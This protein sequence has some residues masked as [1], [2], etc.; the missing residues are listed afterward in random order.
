MESRQFVWNLAKL[1]VVVKHLADQKRHNCAYSGQSRDKSY[2]LDIAYYSSCDEF[3]SGNVTKRQL[4][5]K[6]GLYDKIYGHAAALRSQ[7]CEVGKDRTQIQMSLKTLGI[8]AAS[9][10]KCGNLELSSARQDIFD[11]LISIAD[12]QQRSTV[13]PANMTQNELMIHRSRGKVVHCKM[14][15]FCYMFS[16]IKDSYLSFQYS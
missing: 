5:G 15:C 2:E 8:S 6:D 10:S 12:E 16:T 9:L 11:G 14:L 3:A 1:V 4:H 7:L 13:N